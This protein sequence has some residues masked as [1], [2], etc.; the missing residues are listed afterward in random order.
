LDLLSKLVCDSN[1]YLE[2]HCFFSTVLP[3]WTKWKCSQAAALQFGVFVGLP[4]TVVVG[5]RDQVDHEDTLKGYLPAFFR[6]QPFAS[7][8]ESDIYH[9]LEAPDA[10]ADA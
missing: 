4:V 6:Q 3:S 10:L 1:F 7:C 9:P 5:G 2:P 8:E